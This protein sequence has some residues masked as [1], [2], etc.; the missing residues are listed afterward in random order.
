MYI[1]KNPDKNKPEP[2]KTTTTVVSKT[3]TSTPKPTSTLVPN[4]LG[5]TEYPCCSPGNTVV[6]ETDAL[7]NWGLENDD[8]CFI[9][10]PTVCE[11]EDLGYSCCSPDNTEV[12]A[13]DENGTWGYENEDW[14]GISRIKTTSTTSTATPT[15][16]NIRCG[17]N[18]NDQKCP[19]GQCC[20]RKGY[21]GSTKQ[22]CSMDNGCNIN[23][24]DCKCGEKFGSCSTSYCCSKS[25]YCGTTKAYCG[26]GCQDQYG[27]TCLN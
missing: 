5:I 27:K 2:P 10:K 16:T 23:Y 6:V 15:L 4:C 7:G 3:T 22:Y 20:S 12:I 18:F 1:V 13:T 26:A 8:W 25:G 11:F 21:C 14:C 9:S 17:A 19:K 24:G